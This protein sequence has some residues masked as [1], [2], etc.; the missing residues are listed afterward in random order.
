MIRL[1]SLEEVLSEII[2]DNKILQWNENKTEDAWKDRIKKRTGL[3]TKNFF[4]LI[5]LGINKVQK[6][7]CSTGDTCIIFQKS[8]FILI[9][10][11]DKNKIVT[12][13]DT[14]WDKPI[15]DK[16]C[17]RAIVFESEEHAR[18][19]INNVFLNEM[20][21]EGYSLQCTDN[22]LELEIKTNCNCCLEIDL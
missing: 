22:I 6:Q 9:I 4:E 12:I 10:N 3:S 20:D 7:I 21:F 2:L 5:Q 16:P 19:I 17:K 13:R 15:G 11:K 14:S 18:D 8:K 1:R